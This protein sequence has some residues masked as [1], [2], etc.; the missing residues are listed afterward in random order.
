[1]V[2]PVAH[3]PVITNLRYSPISALQ[4]PGGLVTLTGT[5]DFSDA[6]AN[7]AVLHLSSNSGPELTV[8]VAL[9]GVTSGTLIGDFLVSI[10][11]VG[12]YTFEIWL[13][14]SAG[15]TS[16]HLGGTFDVLVNDTAT[17]WREVP[18][19]L[20]GSIL[21]G[22]AWNG[23]TYVA[24]GGIGTAGTVIT[25]TD[26]IIWTPQSTP[27]S[28]PFKSAAWSGST[29][30]VVGDDAAGRAVILNSPDAVNWTLSYQTAPCTL[31]PVCPPVQ[32]LSKVIWA[33]TQ[34]VSVGAETVAGSPRSAL[35]MTSPDG[36]S[37]TQQASGLIPVGL[38]EGGMTSIA[39]SG[40]VLVAAGEAPDS[41]A[42][43]WRSTD[44]VNWSSQS[45]PL[46]GQSVLRDVAWGASGFVVVGWGGIPATAVSTD[47]IVWRANQDAGY[48][49]AMN[50]V[51]AGPTRYLAVSNTSIETSTTAETWSATPTM[52]SC[53]NAVLWDGRRWV[54]FGAEV[55]L[56][57]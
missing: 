54:S 36:V 52:R 33:G 20:G 7:V 30:V 49:S 11:L 1:V 26:A 31:P 17:T 42:A 2:A 14:D 4:S 6:G 50:A 40:S 35:V 13:E 21:M 47:G 25:S 22:A 16:N 38:T 28:A 9:P 34:F 43:V 3:P 15:N 57:P 37:W 5:F 39:W 27:V 8:P 44:A 19:S 12:H 32:A 53:G 45:L 23:A 56:S 29:W 18:L 46:T 51:G 24:V 48:L 41:T 55:C 10:D